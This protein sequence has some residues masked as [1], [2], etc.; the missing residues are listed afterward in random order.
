MKSIY[1]RFLHGFQR[2]FFRS[3]CTDY[4]RSFQ[5]SLFLPR[6]ASPG[7]SA[8]TPAEIPFLNR[9]DFSRNF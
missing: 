8:G 5:G 2:H 4:L 3:F 1:L 7:I 9:R 6:N